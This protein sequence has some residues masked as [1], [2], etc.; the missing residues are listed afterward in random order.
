MIEV[1]AKFAVDAAER[2]FAA[3]QAINPCEP[4]EES[5][6]SDEYFN[7]PARD[8]RI[9]DEALRIRRTGDSVQ[10]TWK[11]PRL[12][13]VTKS[14]KELELPIASEVAALAFTTNQLR[15]ILL[16]LGFVP[17]GIVRKKRKTTTLLFEDRRFTV[18]FDQVE[19]LRF[20]AELEILCE[21]EQRA[22]ATASLLR[23]AEFLGL[24]QSERRSYIE[25]VQMNLKSS[26]QAT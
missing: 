25:L 8:F 13:S 19:G 23:L 17:A 10:L 11:G 26:E 7:H 12:D 14:R 15:D 5:E 6:E 18:S 22:S 2:L 4:F 16:A 9:T 24:H 1:E 3:V 21:E 20:Y